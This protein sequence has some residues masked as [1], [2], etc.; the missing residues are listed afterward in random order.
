MDDGF[1]H[2]RLNREL[3]IVLIDAIEPFG[4]GHLLPRGLLREPFLRFRRA[5]IVMATRT[6]MVPSQKLAEIRYRYKDILQMRLG[7]RLDI[8]QCT[9]PI[10]LENKSRSSSCKAKEFL[11]FVG[12][13]SV[14][15]LRNSAKMRCNR[16]GYGDFQNHHAYSSGDIESIAKQYA[17][18]ALPMQKRLT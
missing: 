12:W 8:S 6:D 3:N 9:C 7:S 4:Y 17:V 10:Y 5:D 16:C 15:I 2:R 18:M 11:R 13:K 1:Q 14:G